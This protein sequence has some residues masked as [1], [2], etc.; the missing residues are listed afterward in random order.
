MKPCEEKEAEKL[1]SVILTTTCLS[2]MQTMETVASLL[3]LLVACC[4]Q[5]NCLVRSVKCTAKTNTR[6]WC[7]TSK[8]AIP[9]PC[10]SRNFKKTLECTP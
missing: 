1:S 10:S 3:S 5:I 7:S 9:V 6:R 8:R 2:I 4:I